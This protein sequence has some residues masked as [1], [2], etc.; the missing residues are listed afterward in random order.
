M[1]R[2]LIVDDSA[3]MRRVMGD[4]FSDRDAFELAF[5]RTGEEALAALHAFKPNVITLDVNMPG[6]GGLACL[7]RIM[8]ERP[9]PVVMVSALTEDGATTTLEA[10]ELGAVD[11]V[12]KPVGPVTLKIDELAELLIEKVRQ[13]ATARVRGSFRLAE[14]VRLRT[15]GP[16]AVRPVRAPAKPRREPRARKPG[17]APDRIVL[18]GCSTGGPQALD[19]LLEG[20]PASF[21]WPLVVAQHMPVAF[22]G[23]LARRL[24]ASCALSVREVAAPE[25][26][27]RGVVYIARGDAD[28]LLTVRAGEAVALPAPASAEYRWHPSVDRLVHSAIDRLGAE[29]LV[30]VLMTGM[31][32]DGADSMARLHAGGGVTVAEAETTAVVWGMPGELVRAGGA[33]QVAP[34]DRIAAELMALAEAG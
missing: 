2:L 30:G 10:L 31:G 26:I 18:V 13:A 3:L 33:T 14:R 19:V 28:L 27:E 34:L 29:R 4:I 25:Q 16:P 8:V 21:P 5:A 11:F 22:T 15:G 9:C 20:L 1:I 17:Q 7:D 12:P 23:A 32:S 6:M 24:D